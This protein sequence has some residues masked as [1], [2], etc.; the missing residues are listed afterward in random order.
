MK[1]KHTILQLHHKFHYLDKCI[2][3][4]RP[5][6]L[7]QASQTLNQIPKPLESQSPY[8]KRLRY[9]SLK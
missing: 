5:E 7:P 2:V 9:R 6:P 3:E 1:A 4:S 8:H